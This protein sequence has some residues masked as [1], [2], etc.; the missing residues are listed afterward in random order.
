MVSLVSPVTFVQTRSINVWLKV[1]P[2]HLC[3]NVSPNAS[4]C[5]QRKHQFSTHQSRFT[6]S[7]HNA[8]STDT[9][10][11]AA[12]TLNITSEQISK[13]GRFINLLLAANQ[14]QNLTAIRRPG[15]IITKHILD[16]F[17]LLPTL[18]YE[19]PCRMID[20][21]SGAGLPG[22]VIAIARPGIHVTLL[23]SVRKKT[24]FH[25]QVI[26]DLELTNVESVWARAEDAARNPDHRECY[27]LSVARSVA[28][29]SALAELCLPFVRVNGAFVAQKMVD[30]CHSEV[31][32]AKSAIAQLGGRLSSVTDAWPASFPQE[33]LVKS[34][35]GDY[36]TKALVIVRKER[37]TAGRYPRKPG[38]P[39]KSPLR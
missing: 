6:C 4:L 39:V 20:I 7:L 22:F 24:M 10:R 21:G 8:P 14:K 9:F 27:C 37:P 17:T 11:S 3:T 38:I 25:S 18:D 30:A 28:R 12:A 26:A 23:D 2:V 19:D 36:R 34:V 5:T 33:S 15:D 1:R 16:A 13:L 31:S 29:M 32:D 35:D